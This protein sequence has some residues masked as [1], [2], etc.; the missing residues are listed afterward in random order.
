MRDVFP[1]RHPRES[2]DP[3]KAG[4]AKR[5]TCWLGHRN[6]PLHL[7]LLAVALASPSLW[8]GWQLDD[9][10]HRAALTGGA[11]FQEVRRSP[12]ELFAFVKGD[13]ETNR[14][15]ISRGF[16]PWWTR[17]DLRLA[18]FRPVSGLTHWVDYQL[19]PNSP[20]LMHAHSLVWFGGVVCLASLLYRRIIRPEW[21]AGLAALLFAVEDSH[22]IPAVW[23]ASRNAL[24]GLF[25]GLL[26]LNLHDRWRREAWRMGAYLAPAAFVLGLLSNEGAVAAAAYLLAYALFLDRGAGRRRLASLMPYT[27]LGVVWWLAYKWMGYGANGS[28][29]YIDPGTTPLRFAHALTERAPILLFGQWALPSALWTLLSQPV[30]RLAWFGAVGFAALLALFLWPLMRRSPEA[31]FWGTGMVLS[32]VPVCAMVPVDRLLSFPGIGGTALLALFIAAVLGKEDWLPTW[33]LWRPVARVA[34]FAFIAVHLVL[35]PLNLM[36]AGKNTKTFGQIA[37]RAAESLPSGPSVADKQVAIVHTPS[38]FVSI[39]S[40]FL[41]ALQGKKIPARTILLASSIYPTEVRRRDERTLVVR[42]EGGYVAPPGSPRPG[43]EADQ[44]PFSILYPLQLLDRLFRDD[45]PMRVGERIELDGLSIEV[46]DVTPDGRP[47]E[48]AFRFDAPLEDPSFL[49]LRWQNGKFVT[50]FLPPVGQT[51]VLPEPK[52]PF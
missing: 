14:R 28:G 32:L 21:L 3:E 41:N 27:L 48:V 30:A 5:V 31:R 12:A 22:G 7:S 1:G 47:A 2:G 15:N 24:I 37:D 40:A 29:V 36:L 4:L 49:W 43:H 8:I 25:F 26:C 50:F 42:P 39:H 19:W 10:I 35:S 51:T 20:S 6:L 16:W 52:V 44:A 11:E 45:R 34:C 9:Y 46:E 23:I 13:P 33:P 17:P 18:F 38:A